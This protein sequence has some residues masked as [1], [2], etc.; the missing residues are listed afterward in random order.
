[1]KSYKYI[2]T[3][4][5]YLFICT[6]MLAVAVHCAEAATIDKTAVRTWTAKREVITE[7]GRNYVSGA[8]TKIYDK[9]AA[10]KER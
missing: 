3:K 4:P 7:S 1:M 10:G 2:T 6:V 9:W 5:L 8:D